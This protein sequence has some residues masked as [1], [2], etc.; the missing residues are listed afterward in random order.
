MANPLDD[1]EARI[2][3]AIAAIQAKQVPSARQAAML[4]SVP[5]STLQDRLSGKRKANK[6]SKQHLQRLSVE[7]EEALVK[8]VYQLDA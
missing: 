6:T 7:E 8:A 5:R 2:Q 4:F 1:Q 3:A